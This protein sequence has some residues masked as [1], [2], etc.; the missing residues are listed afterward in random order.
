MILLICI[1]HLGLCNGWRYWKIYRLCVQNPRFAFT[2]ANSLDK[3]AKKYEEAG[4][5]KQANLYKSFAASVRKHNT[6][7]HNKHSS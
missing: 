5:I 7:Y 3:E 4:M 1:Y 2:W 6:I